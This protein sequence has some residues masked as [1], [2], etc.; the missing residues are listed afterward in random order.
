MKLRY[1]PEARR[2]AVWWRIYFK[3]SFPQGAGKAA[4]YLRVSEQVLKDNPQIGVKLDIRDLR[5]L[6]IPRTP[7]ALIYRLTDDAIEIVRLYDMRQQGST[8]F[9]E[10]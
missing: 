10:D 7:F 1:L 5:K 2:D 4:Q 6:S 8:E 9:Q 3:R